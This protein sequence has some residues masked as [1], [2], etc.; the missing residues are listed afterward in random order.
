MVSLIDGDDGLPAAEVGIWAKTKHDYLRRYVD[1]TRGVRAKWTDPGKAGATYIDPYCGPG[2]ARIKGT[3]TFIEGSAVVAWQMSVACHVPFSEI[4]IADL[5]P[6]CVK[7][8]EVRLKALGAPVVSHVGSALATV[9]Q[10]VS[11]L[12]PHDLHFAFLD[13][14]NLEA[15]NFEILRALAKLDRIDILVHLSQMDLQR[16]FDRHTAADAKAFDTFV[17]GWRDLLPPGSTRSQRP[18]VWQ[19]WSEMVGSLGVWRSPTSKLITGKTR[20]P[21]YWLAMLAKHELPHAFW[22]VASN[23]E[24]QGNFDF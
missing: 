1:I 5:D 8:C 6:T 2:R 18:A 22:R 24:R 10:T 9:R 7:A 11:A 19:M 13:P 17:P 14:F 23:P 4:H 12:N 15:L 20:Q 16:N 3:N 21:L